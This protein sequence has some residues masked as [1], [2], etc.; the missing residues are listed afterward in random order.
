VDALQA[1]STDGNAEGVVGLATSDSIA[2]QREEIVSLQ[3]QASLATA[4]TEANDVML[5]GGESTLRR[6]TRKAQ[7][8]KTVKAIG[9]PKQYSRRPKR[10]VGRGRGRKARVEN[11]VAECEL[12]SHEAEMGVKD[13]TDEDRGRDEVRDEW[14]CIRQ[15]I[16]LSIGCT[17]WYTNPCHERTCQIHIHSCL[18]IICN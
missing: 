12:S 10:G 9:S 6:S 16:D 3:E 1:L 11:D 2:R 18:R 5:I 13:A 17:P 4:G 7:A 8:S 15:S 14:H